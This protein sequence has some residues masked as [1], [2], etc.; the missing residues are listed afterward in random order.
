M[1]KLPKLNEI[2]LEMCLQ[3]VLFLTLQVNCDDENHQF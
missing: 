3:M 2:R 1:L